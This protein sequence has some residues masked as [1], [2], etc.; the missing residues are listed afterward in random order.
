MRPRN[1]DKNN[2]DPRVTACQ[3]HSRSEANGRCECRAAYPCQPPAARAVPCNQVPAIV[4]CLILSR[5]A[6][7]GTCHWRAQALR[8]GQP[9]AADAEVRHDEPKP[10]ARDDLITT[11]CRSSNV[12]RPKGCGCALASAT[13]IDL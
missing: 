8:R 5:L 6:G 3:L 13:C 9:R 11:R 7:A 2:D 4:R 1:S 10:K 12:R